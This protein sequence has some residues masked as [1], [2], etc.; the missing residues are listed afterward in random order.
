MTVFIVDDSPLILSKVAE[1]LEEVDGINSLKTCGTYTGAVKEFNAYR[2]SHILIDINLPDGSGIELLQHV[3]KTS[4]QTTVI[5]F[6]NMSGE[7][8]QKLCLNMG[9][10]YFIDKSKDFERIPSILA[11][12]S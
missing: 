3:K 10:D 7:Y 8:Y 2:P 6:T 12:L 9:A 4:P 11:S 1:L 5:M